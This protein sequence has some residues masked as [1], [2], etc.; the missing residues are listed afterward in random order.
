MAERDR[1]G[2]DPSCGELW[3]ASDSFDWKPWVS[4]RRFEMSIVDSF[5]SLLIPHEMLFLLQREFC[6]GPPAFCSYIVNRMFEQELGECRRRTTSLEV[7]R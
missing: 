1:H 5:V 2:R 6:E 7:T 4:S 3:R